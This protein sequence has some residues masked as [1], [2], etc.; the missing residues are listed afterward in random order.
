M[1]DSSVDLIFTSSPYATALDYTR[2]HFL[3]VPWM[4]G[5]LGCTVQEYLNQ[6]GIYIGS[7][8]GR[9]PRDFLIDKTLS[10]LP[11]AK[12]VLTSLSSE[13]TNLAKRI[14]RYF[15]QMGA[16]LTEIR[17][18]LKPGRRAIVVICPSHLRKIPIP[19]HEILTEVAC[20]IGL[21][22]VR[23]HTRTIAERRRLLPYIQKSFGKRMDTEYVMIFKKD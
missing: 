3:A 15:S 1:P 13:S 14:Q 9:F 4:S 17:R 8:R 2:A 12:E 18:V 7:E 19:T 5:A 11:K 6:A 16:V 20:H 10:T 21:Q 23:K 22:F